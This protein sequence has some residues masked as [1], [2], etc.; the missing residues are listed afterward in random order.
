MTIAS[1][2]LADELTCKNGRSCNRHSRPAD[3]SKINVHGIYDVFEIK[4]YLY[5][6]DLE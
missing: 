6:E 3:G 5:I 1:P 4:W 2:T